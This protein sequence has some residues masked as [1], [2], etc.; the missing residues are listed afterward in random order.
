MIERL[1]ALLFYSPD[2]ERLAGFYR[3]ALGIPFEPSTHG[4]AIGQH[5]EGF[6]GGTHFAIWKGPAAE[7]APRMEATYRVRD[8]DRALGELEAREVVPLG[9]PRKLGEGKRVATFRDPD[10]NRFNLIE[11]PGV[12]FA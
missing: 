6:H 5:F 8:L 11:L 7:A 12:P 4:G 10:G 1:S 3:D 9:P 2:P